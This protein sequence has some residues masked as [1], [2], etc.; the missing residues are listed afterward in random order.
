MVSQ[1]SC[2]VKLY[3]FGQLIIALKLLICFC[4]KMGESMSSEPQS[5]HWDFYS[6]VIDDKPHSTFV[7]LSLFDIAPIQTLSMFCGLEVKLKYPH[8]EHGMTTSEEFQ[9]LS[10]M[11]D[12]IGENQTGRLRYVARQTGDRKRK[13]Y[14]YVGSQG[15]FKSLIDRLHQAFPDYET[16]NFSFD[17]VEWRTYFD[18]L[19]PNAMAMNEIT[20]RAV[21]DRLEESGDDLSIPRPIDHF[22]IFTDAKRAKE[23]EKIVKQKGFTVEVDTKGLLKKTVELHLQRVDIPSSLDPITFELEQLAESLGGTYDGW[24]CVEAVQRQ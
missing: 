20:N 12:M 19:Y 7:N 15:D 4:A 18:D 3:S 24:G 2:F 22:V 17:D 11:E 14:F 8:P 13:F 9:I 10:D 21:Y 23:F 1:I 5:D 6:C 16:S